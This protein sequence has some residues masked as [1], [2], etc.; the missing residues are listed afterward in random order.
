MTDEQKAAMIRLIL[1]A[2]PQANPVVAKVAEVHGSRYTVEWTNGPLPEG[3]A[4]FANSGISIKDPEPLVKGVIDEAV[5]KFLG[6][7]LP[8]GFNP[9]NGISFE[10]LSGHQVHTP[11][12]TNLFTAEQAKLMFQHCVEDALRK[13]LAI[14]RFDHDQVPVMSLDCAAGTLEYGTLS[15]ANELPSGHYDLYTAPKE[16]PASAVVSREKFVA[17]YCNGSEIDEATFHTHNIAL[18]CDCGSQA[19]RGWAAVTKDPRRV[20]QHLGIDQ[21]DAPP[22]PDHNGLVVEAEALIKRRR[23]LNWQVMGSVAQTAQDDDTTT[24]VLV[25]MCNALKEVGQKDPKGETPS[26]QED[27]RLVAERKASFVA[28]FVCAGGDATEAKSR[29]KEFQACVGST[30][31]EPTQ[32]DP[33]VTVESSLRFRLSTEQQ[34]SADLLDEVRELKGRVETLTRSRRVLPEKIQKALRQAREFIPYESNREL[35]LQLKA[36]ENGEEDL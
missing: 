24:R 15:A 36:L 11:V 2:N 35:W 13:V 28:G 25:S 14:P 3:T 26:Q 22:S 8:D 23:D 27:P 12:G 18:P 6:W 5:T 7:V 30:E 19:C 9:D 10:K 16:R 4:L 33:L 32:K 31:A 17:D 34:K 21:V 20:L 1:Q 29:A